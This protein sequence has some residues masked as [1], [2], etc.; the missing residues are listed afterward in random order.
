G[1]AL[2]PDA[3]AR[4]A[5]GYLGNAERAHRP[6]RALYALRARCRKTLGDEAAAQVDTQLA[7][8]TPS[9]MALDHF[10]RGQ[11]AYDAKQ[12]AE[13]VQAFE[14]A[15]RLES[16]HYWSLMWLGYCLCD[17]GQS[18]DDFAGAARV[19]TGCVL[20]RPDHA[21]AYYCRANAYSKLRRY[22]EALADHATAIELDPKH[23]D[24]WSGP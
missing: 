12:L 10:L 7:D 4:A 6:T 19:F 14:A 22:E 2:A 17:L 8:Q 1:Q 21:H 20:K 3:A 24:A 18:P 9:T 13:G 23:A 5:L 15:L 11:A 16:T